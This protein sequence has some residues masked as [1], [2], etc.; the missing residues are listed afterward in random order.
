MLTSMTGDEWSCVAVTSAS[1]MFAGRLVDTF[2]L[3]LGMR[4]EMRVGR[5]K[6]KWERSAL[7]DNGD[8]R[9]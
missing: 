2:E 8:K 7:I 4:R 5:E 1:R 3:G 6:Q 9:S